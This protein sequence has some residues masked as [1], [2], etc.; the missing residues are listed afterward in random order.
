MS[1]NVVAFTTLGRKNAF[2]VG[3]FKED[4]ILGCTYN[5]APCNMTSFKLHQSPFYFNCYSFI[6][7]KLETLQ[8]NTKTTQSAPGPVSG[9]SLILNAGKISNRPDTFFTMDGIVKSASGFEIHISELNAYP[10]PH[11][12]AVSVSTGTYNTIALERNKHINLP[13]PYGKCMTN[14]E[15]KKSFEQITNISLRTS[16]IHYN[17]IM[18]LNSCAA[19][20]VYDRCKCLSAEGS[21]LDAIEKMVP[22][23]PYCA[24]ASSENLLRVSNR[25]KCGIAVVKTAEFISHCNKCP[26]PCDELTYSPKVSVVKWPARNET[27]SLLTSLFTDKTHTTAYKSMVSALGIQ[28]LKELD[29][30]YSPRLN[31]N[32]SEQARELLSKAHDWA[33]DNLAYV[34]IYFDSDSIQ[35]RKQ[36]PSYEMAALFSDLGGA[37][38]LYAGISVI[39]ITEVFV[40]W[41]TLCVSKSRLHKRQ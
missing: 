23:V 27:L 20:T 29:A 35:Y 2:A 38:G 6:G 40:F 4:M 17:R 31:S 12:E 18:C 26:S 39:S 1:S 41:L 19:R 22:D 13:P 3:H 30:I 11:I 34:S 28:G 5:R 36:R 25:I 33:V 24:D 9:L 10:M 14:K 7:G 15:A 37:L 8:E 32:R 21:H 16:Y